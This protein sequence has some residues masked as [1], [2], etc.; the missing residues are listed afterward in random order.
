MVRPKRVYCF[1]SKSRFRFCELR[2]LQPK[3][4]Q[5]SCHRIN[6]SNSNRA[7]F[8]IETVLN[9]VASKKLYRVLNAIR[10]IS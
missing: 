5:A 7:D 8:G 10:A 4:A 9:K 6:L 1:E 3:L 2:L